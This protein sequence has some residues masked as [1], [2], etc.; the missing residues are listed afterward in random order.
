MSLVSLLR[1]QALR[2]MKAAKMPTAPTATPVAVPEAKSLAVEVYSGL[3]AEVCA[4]V[5]ASMR[6][7]KAVFVEKV[8][9]FV[10]L[11][12]AAILAARLLCVFFFFCS[13]FRMRDYSS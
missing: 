4:K 13:R 8:T 2:A 6:D 9:D 3:A 11:A 7:L 1:W 5:R 10:F 12:F